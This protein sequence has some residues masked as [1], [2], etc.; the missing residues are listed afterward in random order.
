MRVQDIMTRDVVSIRDDRKLHAA[1]AI[2]QFSKIR[3]LPVV[4]VHGDL[5][6][7]ITRGVI[8]ETQ[9]SSLERIPQVDKDRRLATV[10]VGE[11]MLRDPVTI[12]ADA[13]VHTAAHLMVSRRIGC[14]PV[15]SGT[16]LVGILTEVDLLHLLEERSTP[17]AT[18]VL[19]LVSA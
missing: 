16:S 9:A 12:A 11:V 19:E 14:L 15:T 6:G 4:N 2:M 1:R 10:T 7:L 5:V 17:V 3:H 13:H 8:L 18:R